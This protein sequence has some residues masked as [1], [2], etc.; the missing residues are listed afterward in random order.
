MGVNRGKDTTYIGSDDDIRKQY[1]D[2]THLEPVFNEH[3]KLCI[4]TYHIKSI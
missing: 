4:C 2:K 1:G 3:E